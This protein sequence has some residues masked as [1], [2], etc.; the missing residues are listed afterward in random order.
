MDPTLRRVLQPLVGGNVY[1]GVEQ[2]GMNAVQPGVGPLVVGQRDLGEEL[3][4]SSPGRAQT[5]E[6]PPVLQARRGEHAVD[7]LDIHGHGVRRGPFGERGRLLPDG[8]RLPGGG[9]ENTAG[10]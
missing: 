6:D 9:A 4:T 7:A 5:L 2:R 1:G 8:G 10:V 3:V